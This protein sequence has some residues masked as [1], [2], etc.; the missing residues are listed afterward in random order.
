LGGRGY[1][2]IGHHEI[3]LPLIFAAVKEALAQ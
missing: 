3:N 2:L 1:Y